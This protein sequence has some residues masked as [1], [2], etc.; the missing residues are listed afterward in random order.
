MRSTLLE[1]I[2]A[3][4]L[5][6]YIGEGGFNSNE[7]SPISIVGVRAR[8]GGGVLADLVAHIFIGD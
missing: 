7:F 3:T 4:Y 2:L 1:D 6:L 5:A 8:I